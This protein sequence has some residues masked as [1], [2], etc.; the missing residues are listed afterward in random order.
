MDIIVQ[1]LVRHLFQTHEIKDI[2]EYPILAQ[3]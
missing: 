2:I 1:I 3:K